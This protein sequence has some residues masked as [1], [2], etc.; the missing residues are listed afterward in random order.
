MSIFEVVVLVAFTL[1]ALYMFWI[2]YH[3][4]DGMI[5]KNIQEALSEISGDWV[6]YNKE[7]IKQM[8]RIQSQYADHFDESI[9]DFKT[10]QELQRQTIERMKME[11]AHQNAINGSLRHENVKLSRIVQKT[12]KG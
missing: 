10:A 4:V 8:N 11:I 5:V 1:G 3:I 7:M 6:K 12:K 2:H 9:Q